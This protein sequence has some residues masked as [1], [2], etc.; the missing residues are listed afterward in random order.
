MKFHKPTS[1][2]TVLTELY[3][4]LDKDSKDD[5][6]P[7][8]KKILNS[9]TDDEPSNF[10]AVVSDLMKKQENLK[11]TAKNQVRVLS[12]Q[13]Q[14]IRNAAL[15]LMKQQRSSAKAL[16]QV[17]MRLLFSNFCQIR[18]IQEIPRKKFF[19]LEKNDQL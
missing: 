2:S 19:C 4:Y 6:K 18:L 7:V 3:F 15:E 17:I 14:E 10:V 8:E 9:T 11:E 13:E 1:S 5:S 16:M 12:A